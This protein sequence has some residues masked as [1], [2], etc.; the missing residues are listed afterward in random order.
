MLVVE[1]KFLVLRGIVENR[2]LTV[3]DHHQLLFLKR[4][5]PAYE[6]MSAHTGTEVKAGHGHVG[7]VW[8]DVADP[9]AGHLWRDSSPTSRS[10]T[11]ISWGAKLH[12]A[13]SSTRI[14]PKFS[15]FE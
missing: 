13:F 8:G 14:L 7:Q 6:D 11:A 3:S 2:H 12:K 1:R 10:I 4:I 9:G 5:E 15:R